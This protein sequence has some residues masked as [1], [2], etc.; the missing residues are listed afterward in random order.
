MSCWEAELWIIRW[1][2]HHCGG[3]VNLLELHLLELVERLPSKVLGKS[4][5][6]SFSAEVF[7]CLGVGV[8]QAG[9]GFWVFEEPCPSEAT[10]SLGQEVVPGKPLAWQELGY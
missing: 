10:C 5:H 6:R 7:H 2:I 9:D 4:A 8:L 1:Q 3:A